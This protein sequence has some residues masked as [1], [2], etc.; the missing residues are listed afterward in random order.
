M[1][2]LLLV[3]LIGSALLSCKKKTTDSDCKDRICTADFRSITI[4]FLDDKA[5]DAEVR[6][7]S[8]VNQRNGERVYTNS[9]MAANLTKGTYLVVDDGNTKYLSEEGDNL[10]ITGTSVA[11]NQTKSAII[12]VTGGT[13]ACHIHKVSGPEQITF[14]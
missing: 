6:D 7:F 14:D 11:T 9:G 2:K 13:C 12:K 5:L 4:K 1:K 8:V 10:K 3:L